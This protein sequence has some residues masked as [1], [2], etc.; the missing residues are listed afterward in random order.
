MATSYL[1]DKGEVTIPKALCES[2]QWQPGQCLEV[3]DTPEGILLKRTATFPKTRLE[4]VAGSLAYDG[5]RIN[6]DE[7]EQT[8][9]EGTQEWC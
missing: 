5:P 1:T 3:I 7:M 9:M 8:I 4:D 2:R 6:L